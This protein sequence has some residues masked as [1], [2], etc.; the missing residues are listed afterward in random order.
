MAEFFNVGQPGYY[1]LI[2]IFVGCVAAL[3]VFR[4]GK[5]RPATKAENLQKT[6]AIMTK[7]LLD[8]TPDEKLVNAV[9][10]NL[11]EK[12]PLRR[13][14]PLITIPRLSHG[15]NAVYFCWMLCKEIEHNGVE[16]I[17]KK[18]ASRF[19]DV[20]IEGLV[21]VGANTTADAVRAFVTPVA[22]SVAA[23]GKADVSIEQDAPEAAVLSAIE[24][25]QPLSLCVEYIRANPEEFLDT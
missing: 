25:E 23:I 9:V 1:L 16:A 4:N 6:Y 15:R 19:V 3:F 18:P 8:E 13:P 24:A 22:Q 20:G 5:K 7:E 14:D 2:L 10:A 17:L 11:M 12:L 21:T